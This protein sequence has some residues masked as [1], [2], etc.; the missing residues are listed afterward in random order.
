MRITKG[1]AG[2]KFKNEG[3]IRYLIHIRSKAALFV[4]WILQIKYYLRLSRR[5]YTKTNELSTYLP[6][7]A[8]ISKIYLERLGLMSVWVGRLM[9]QQHRFHW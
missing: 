5:L 6:C 1:R 4:T 8:G 3:T 7:R 2:D 9:L